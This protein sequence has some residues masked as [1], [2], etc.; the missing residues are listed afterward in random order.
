MPT[1]FDFEGFSHRVAETA[2]RELAN[3]HSE[4]ALAAA[5]SVHRFTDEALATSG[6]DTSMV[7][8][9]PGCGSCCEVNVAV[10]EPEVALIVHHLRAERDASDLQLLAEKAATLASRVNGL[11]DE[12]RLFLR[13]KCIFL[14]RDGC[15]SIHPVRPLLC[16]SVT[17]TD[18]ERCRDAIAMVAL[19]ETVQVMTHLDQQEFYQQAFVG[20]ATAMKRHGLPSRSGNL[21]ETAA[22][23]L[24]N[25]DDFTP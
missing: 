7:A 10:L 4:S 9:E 14:D 13:E 1:V 18:P 6:F 12:E 19:G 22:R 25:P 16:R 23:L 8:C 21:C 24:N 17:S 15:C 5:E 11:D 2:G 20:L 3:S